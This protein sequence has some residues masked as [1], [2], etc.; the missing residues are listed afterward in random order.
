MVYLAHLIL[1]RYIQ[2]T[3]RMHLFRLLDWHNKSIKHHKVQTLGRVALPPPRS[4][5]LMEKTCVCKMPKR[6]RAPKTSSCTDRRQLPTWHGCSLPQG[7]AAETEFLY[8][9]NMPKGFVLCL[10]GWSSA[11]L[12]LKTCKQFGYSLLVPK[13]NIDYQ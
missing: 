1:Q 12:W 7:I 13:R 3:A 6:P 11:L 8:A 10:F 9:A 5:G 2:P 4:V